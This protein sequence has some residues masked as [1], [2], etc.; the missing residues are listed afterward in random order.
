[1]PSII[2]K[3]S[4]QYENPGWHVTRVLLLSET[5]FWSLGFTALAFGKSVS[6]LLL[7][8]LQFWFVWSFLT[9]RFRFWTFGK[10]VIQGTL[11]SQGIVF[12]GTWRL[13]VRSYLLVRL[14]PVTWLRRGLPGLSRVATLSSLS[15][16]VSCEARFLVNTPLL[17]RLLP[18]GL[19]IHGWFLPE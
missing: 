9:V 16:S 6:K 8:C 12:R 14:T 7:E 4:L 2:P 10:S 17:L 18:V 3:M 5:V 1:M 11:C 13:S 19:R 15:D